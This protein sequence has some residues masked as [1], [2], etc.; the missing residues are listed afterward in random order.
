[1]MRAYAE[2]AGCRRQL[3]LGYFGESLG[4]PCGNCDRCLE[5]AAGRGGGEEASP[6]PLHSWVTH[7]AWGRGQVLDSSD[8]KLVVFFEGA[9]Y[10]TLALDVVLDRGL[11]EAEG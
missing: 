4:D 11:L 8:G 2:S 6:F 3:L 5:G 7:D 1:M 10:K 9:G